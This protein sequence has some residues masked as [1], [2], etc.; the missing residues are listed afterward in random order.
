MD[1]HE[2]AY[3]LADKIPACGDYAKQAALVLTKQA[4]ELKRNRAE[5]DELAIWLRWSLNYVQIDV[6]DSYQFEQAS[7]VL[8]KHTQPKEQQA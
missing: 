1:D 2:L 7:A 6:R 8:S 3:W 4:D 5:I